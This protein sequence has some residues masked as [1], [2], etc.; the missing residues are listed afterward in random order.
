MLQTGQAQHIQ[1]ACPI[2][3]R[4]ANNTVA[5]CRKTL[6]TSRHLS[7]PSFPPFYY[8]LHICKRVFLALRHFFSSGRGSSLVPW[9]PWHAG[10]QPGPRTQVWALAEVRGTYSGGSKWQAHSGRGS[11]HVQLS[12]P[13]QTHVQVQKMSG[14][15]NVI[16]EIVECHQRRQTIPAW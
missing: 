4:T 16:Y 13:M 1:H 2:E 11:E 3:K 7:C 14:G 6:T 15:Y 8:Y 12:R 10:S 5:Y 9:A